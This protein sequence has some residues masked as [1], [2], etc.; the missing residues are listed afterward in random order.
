MPLTLRL[1]YRHEERS[2]TATGGKRYNS[3]YITSGFI[4][5]A[6]KNISS[7]A[8]GA[9]R[10]CFFKFNNQAIDNYKDIGIVDI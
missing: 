4:A 1:P 9:S 10:Q 8:N 3:L 5:L 6:T 2:V 7:T